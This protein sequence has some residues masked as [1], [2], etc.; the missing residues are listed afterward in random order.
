[1]YTR[2]REPLCVW[3]HVAHKLAQ[4]AVTL[5]APV[6]TIFAAS[7]SPTVALLESSSLA[8]ARVRGWG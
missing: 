3:S 2:W 1:M 7:Y 5:V 8:Q 4:T 6:G